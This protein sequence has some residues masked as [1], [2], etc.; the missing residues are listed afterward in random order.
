[1][2]LDWQQLFAP[3]ESLVELAIRGS[4]MYFVLLT[5]LRI[6]GRR[7]VGSLS[8]MDLLLMVLIA[9]AAQNGMVGEYTSI[10][11]GVVLCGTL[12]GWN[13]AFDWLAYRFPWFARLLTPPPLP[14]VHDGKFMH[15]HLKAELLT[16]EEV[17]GLLREQG[18]FDVREVQLAYIEGDG[19]LSIKRF[20]KQNSGTQ[21]ANKEKGFE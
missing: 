8:M 15:K 16:Y 10:T 12:V 2:T 3:T 6:L 9:D 11:E 20:K 13:F 18:V 5:M 17:L 7:H 21:H 14:I 19:G 4:M 1:V